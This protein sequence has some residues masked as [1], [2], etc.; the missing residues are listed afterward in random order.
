MNVEE[1]ELIE[2][3]SQEIIVS[4]QVKFTKQPLDP[5]QQTSPPSLNLNKFQ[6]N[7]LVQFQGFISNTHNRQTCVTYYRRRMYLICNVCKRLNLNNSRL[8]S[9]GQ[10]IQNDLQINHIVL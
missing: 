2:H 9:K 3:I 4:Q 6:H 1:S 10:I 7:I 8:S 5:T